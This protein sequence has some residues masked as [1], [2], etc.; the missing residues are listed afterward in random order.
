MVGNGAQMSIGRNRSGG[1][2]KA[3]ENQKGGVHQSTVVGSYLQ[4]II[5]I[6]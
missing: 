2:G 6:S 4:G 1:L 3:K 5:H